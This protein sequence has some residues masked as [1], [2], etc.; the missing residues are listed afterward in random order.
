MEVVKYLLFFFNLLFWLSGLILIVTG[1]V[2]KVKYGDYL[3]FADNKY[4]DAALFLIS[5]GVIVFVIAFLGC[6][7]A[8]RD[9]EMSYK[10]V[11]TFAVLLVIIFVL[12]IAAAVLGF[13]YQTKV[14][15]IVEEALNR[16][17]KNYH[18]EKGAKEFYD[19]LQTEL[20]CCGNHGQSDWGVFPPHSCKTY[21]VGCKEKFEN[22]VQKNFIL[23]GGVGLAF[24]LLQIFGI[25]FACCLMREIR[26]KLKGV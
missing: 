19:W 12:E 1:A 16:G 21:A 4:A 15:G 7:G 11:T 14:E 5:V 10:M 18:K 8:I 23:I 2:I 13:E 25:I 20:R 9:S 3:T 24:A 26:G 22:F 6:C 17:I